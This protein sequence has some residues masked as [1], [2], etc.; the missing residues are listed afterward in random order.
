MNFSRPI[1]ELAAMRSS[2]R[3][4]S[5]RPLDKALMERIGAMLKNLPFPPFSGNVRFDLV[6]AAG[7]FNGAPRRLGTYGVIRGAR[8]FIVGAVRKAPHAMEDFGYLMEAVI[9]GLTDLGLGTCWLGG[10]FY[11]SE[12]ARSIGATDEEVVPAITPVGYPAAN[13]GITDRIIR[14][15]AGS[16]KRRAMEELF[17]VSD[18]SRSAEKAEIGPHAE[19][20]EAVRMAPSA[21]NLQP[22][23]LVLEEN[24]GIVHFFLVRSRGYDRIIR[25]VDL[26]RIDMGIAMC[27]FE[28][29]KRDTAAP[30]RWDERPPCFSGLSEKT[31]YIASWVPE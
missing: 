28:M 23:R 8:R 10:T 2:H 3:S 5:S 31:E 17:F 24:T 11:R 9:L 6:D 16:K 7:H 19:A 22:W 1:T 21:S 15:S 30:G 25:A 29:S 14:W 27:H 18:F 13:R 12:F 20:L 26:Q 4:F